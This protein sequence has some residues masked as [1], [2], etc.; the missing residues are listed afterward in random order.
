VYE[1]I[2]MKRILAAL[3]LSAHAD[4]AFAR[5]AQLAMQHE[6]K[7][8]LVHIVR[9]EL[10]NYDSEA[11][12]SLTD[13]ALERAERKLREY[14]LPAPLDTNFRVAIG[15]PARE[16]SRLVQETEA[17]LIVLGL[18]HEPPIRDMFLDTIAY[19]TI[20]RSH[21]PVLV[22]KERTRGPYR[23]VLVPT[24]FSPCAKRALHAAVALAPE[25]EFHVLNVYETPFPQFIHFSEEELREYQQ[26]RLSQI[27]RDVQEEMREFV[28]HDTGCRFPDIKPLL[29]R[30]DT[31]PG[32]TKTIQQLQPD[33]LA[34]GLKR[35]RI[36]YADP[37]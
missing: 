21:V 7:L 34:M 33:L 24:D 31:D 4:R 23:R 10:S 37:K 32:I 6:A 36:C 12:S 2:R 29:E 19:C 3:D 20:Q 1:D 25:A 18:H 28:A 16:I 11:E 30:N 15:D 35:A 27:E 9:K 17:E 8:T 14:S 22:V 13:V 5:A 26:E